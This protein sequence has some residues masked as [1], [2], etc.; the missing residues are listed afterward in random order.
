MK[1]N[2]VDKNMQVI[3]KDQ[4]MQTKKFQSSDAAYSFEF[5]VEF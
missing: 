5:S 4:T 1:S 2:S 3:L